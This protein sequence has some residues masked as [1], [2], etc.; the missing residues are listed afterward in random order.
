MPALGPHS[1]LARNVHGDR[2]YA[3][4]WALPPALSSWSV[5]QTIDQP[6]M[7]EHVNTVPIC[8]YVISIGI[9]FWPIFFIAL[10]AATS[11]YISIPPPYNHVYSTGGPTGEVHAINASS[12]GFGEEV[13]Q[14]LLVPADELAQADKTSMAL[15]STCLAICV[16]F[17]L[18][19]LAAR[20]VIIGKRFSL[21][22]NIIQRTRVHSR[23][24]HDLI[25]PIVSCHY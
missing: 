15:V 13:Q 1:Y 20:L 9:E 6:W 5:D 8:M 21:H 22:W 18:S 7:V 24:V 3:T 23:S 11:G 14:I 19:V 17:V 10:I 2:V 25:W 16:H 12:G 4:S